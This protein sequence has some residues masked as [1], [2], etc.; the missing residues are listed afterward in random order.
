MADTDIN[1]IFIRTKRIGRKLLLSAYSDYIRKR[2][3]KIYTST[4]L[5]F[6]PLLSNFLTVTQVARIAKP[7]YNILV[8][9]QF[10]VNCRAPDSCFL[11]GKGLLDMRNAL[12]CRQ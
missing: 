8:F 11:I 2:L 7:W 5:R 1:I 9:V 3:R 4:M 6:T 10:F 12:W